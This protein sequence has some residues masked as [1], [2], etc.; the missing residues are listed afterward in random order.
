MIN[1]I[2]FTPTATKLLQS[3]L[4]ILI[5]YLISAVIVKFLTRHIE[6]V[7]ARY[8]ARR[9]TFNVAML[10]I[11]AAI[12]MIWITDIP[13]IAVMLSVI[14]A[15]LVLALQEVILSIAGW[16]VIVTRRPFD[17]GD[18]IEMGN[19]KGDVIDI[20]LLHTSLLEIGNWVKS[21]QSTGRVVHI[22]NSAVFKHSLFNF[23]RG[24]EFIWNEI[25]VV[26]TFESDW[27]KAE[28]LIL[29]NAQ[30]EAKELGERVSNLIRRM[31][32]RYLIYYE[33][34]TPIVYV[35]IVDHGVEL[36]LRYLTDAKKR[37]DTQ[38]KICKAILEVFE[39]EKDINFAYPTY[40]IVKD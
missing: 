6:D 34:L 14:G 28:E 38:D 26:V 36:T 13:S 5:I 24:F 11:F 32:R 22:P 25:S 3:A 12:V 39:K 27:K 17:T 4:A 37:R 19:V 23:T 8:H 35:N 31:S 21:D 10:L 29:N 1:M 40:R 20:K 15:G 7:R 33:K 18:R 9:T 2:E 30:E 16:L